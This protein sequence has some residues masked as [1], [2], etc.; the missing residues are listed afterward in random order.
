MMLAGSLSESG[1]EESP[2]RGCGD[3]MW[4][5][6]KIQEWRCG[7]LPGSIGRQVPVAQMGVDGHRTL[8]GLERRGRHAED[9]LHDGLP[10]GR[11]PPPPRLAVQ[12]PPAAAVGDEET[13]RRPATIRAG[14]S[15]LPRRRQPGLPALPIHLRLAQLP[16]NGC[17]PRAGWDD[18]RRATPGA[19]RPG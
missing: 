3:W 10:R 9:P 15:T 16:I 17:H 4:G 7:R 13:R 1:Q 14:R 19:C 5:W 6:R 8:G 11:S 2:P 12:V 18:P